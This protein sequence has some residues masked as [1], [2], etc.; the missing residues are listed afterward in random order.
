MELW[1]SVLSRPEPGLALLGFGKR[2]VPFDIDLPMPE[3]A[4]L[5]RRRYPWRRTAC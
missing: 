5:A 4:A 2:D 3:I 1:G